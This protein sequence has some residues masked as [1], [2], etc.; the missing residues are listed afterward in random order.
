[1]HEVSTDNPRKI[2]TLVTCVVIVREP[3]ATTPPP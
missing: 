2:G 1:V 3:V